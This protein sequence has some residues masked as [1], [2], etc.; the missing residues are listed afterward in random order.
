MTHPRRHSL[1][2]SA[3]PLVAVLVGGLGG[4]AAAAPTKPPPS[5]VTTTCR[6]GA[7][8]PLIVLSCGT[9]AVSIIPIAGAE[10]AMVGE[11][12][13]ALNRKKALEMD[14]KAMERKVPPYV[15][16]VAGEGTR[17]SWMQ[18]D[19]TLWFFDS[20][21][22]ADAVYQCGGPDD[23]DHHGQCKELLAWVREVGVKAAADVV[24]P[25]GSALP[26]IVVP[27]GCE[28]QRVP[29]PVHVWLCRESNMT[30]LTV[31]PVGPDQKNASDATEAMAPMASEMLKKSG[32]A[33]RT[34]KSARCLMQKQPVDCLVVGATKATGA[35]AYVVV[36]AGPVAGLGQ[37]MAMCKWEGPEAGV[38]PICKGVLEQVAKPR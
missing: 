5:W 22:A 14:P 3:L 29:P 15:A 12:A 33:V 32:W 35:E 34:P 10:P 18:T 25:A 38:P 24:V 28:K 31:L 27:P 20:F 19:G 4:P 17:Q 8:A 21:T 13:R 23:K 36:A 2:P 6:A 16:G 1:L 37:G 7:P 11:Q 30:E 9:L 26:A